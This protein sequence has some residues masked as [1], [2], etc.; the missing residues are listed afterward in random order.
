LCFEELLPQIRAILF[1]PKEPEIA[2]EATDEGVER[3]SHAAEAV[4]HHK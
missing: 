3:K 4:K 2:E 1:P